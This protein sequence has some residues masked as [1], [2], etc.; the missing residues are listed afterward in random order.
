[1]KSLEKDVQ[2]VKVQD[3]SYDVNNPRGET[4]QQIQS[5][6]EFKKLVLS[7]KQYGI[8]EPLIVKKDENNVNN[9]K[10]IDGER[11]L[12]A[13]VKV[14]ESDLEYK[15][16]TLLAK[17][18]M[19]GRILA[20]QVH[21]LRKNW[22]KAAETKSIKSIIED[23]KK[24][25]PNISDKELKDRLKEI[26]AHKPHEIEDLLKL[27]KYEDDI[28]EKVISKELDMSYLVQIESNFINPLKRKYRA[29]A[30]KYGEDNLR[31]ILVQKAIDGLLGN[32]RFLMDY[33]KHV[34]KDEINKKIVKDLL[35]DYLNNKEKDIKDTFKE[36]LKTN[37]L[38]S[39]ETGIGKTNRRTLR[40]KTIKKEKDDSYK[41]IKLTPKQTTS[42]FDIRKEFENIGRKLTKE[43][44][45]YIAE[46][47][48]CFEKHCRK[49]AVLM[50]WAS[51]M[52][53]AINYI[54]KDL[55]DFRS[56]CLIMAKSK[57]PPY[58]Y[59]NK[60]LQESGG[61]I[62]TIEDVRD[63]KDMTLILYLLYKSTITMSQ[64]KKLKADYDTRCDCAHPTDIELSFHEVVKIF[65]NIYS[66]IFRKI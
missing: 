52:S 12:R 13:A 17:D 20:Y 5:D 10:L 8:L 57:K 64:Y 53:R 26:T 66:L 59:Y 1:M 4:E 14:A 25:E 40:K 36:Y 30:M 2:Y 44:I 45:E 24:E 6:P 49:A 28:I 35:T 56:S 63:G 43:E 9:F 51:G 41:K 32:T 54:S 39:K 47:L 60:V 16:P 27:I 31:T 48:Y 7:I 38:L 18:D 58:K 3:I 37:P 23:I 19:D 15:V 34:L 29:L 55:D 21:M 11:R 33:F 65:E 42:L 50:I 61:K 46:A 22:G 62:D